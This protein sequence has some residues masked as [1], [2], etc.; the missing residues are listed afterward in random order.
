MVK[1]VLILAH[2]RHGPVNRHNGRILLND[3]P[4]IESVLA[5]VFGLGDE[6]FVVT[7]APQ[8]FRY[9]GVPLVTDL[10]ER[11]SDLDACSI[12]LRQAR[13]RDVL[14]IQDNMPFLWRKLLEFQFANTRKGDAIVPE[15]FNEAQHPYHAVYNRERLLKAVTKGKQDGKYTLGSVLDSLT[16][17]K[18]TQPEVARYSPNGL[19]FMQVHTAAD[20]RLAEKLLGLTGFARHRARE[21]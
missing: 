7:D 16:V 3:Q 6:T 21:V 17:H 4:M 9:L 13:G 2:G 12:G 14:I 1:T 8:H 5:K 19:T 11:P 20:V 15:W 10:P 18:V